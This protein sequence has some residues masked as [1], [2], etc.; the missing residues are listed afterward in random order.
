[1]TAS[2]PALAGTTERGRLRFELPAEL[3]AAT[4]AEARGLSRD[5]VRM[6]VARKG[7]GAIAHATFADLPAF[8]AAGDLVVVNTSGTLAAAI[9]ATTDTGEQLTVHLSTSLPADLWVVELRQGARPYTGGRPGTVL[10][11]PGR[12]TVDVLAP[13]ARS[14]GRLWVAALHLPDDAEANV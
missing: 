6:L 8:L 9:D 12:A 2:T 11:L 5:A 7:E 14:R 13:Y 3:E 10:T 1:V 4:P